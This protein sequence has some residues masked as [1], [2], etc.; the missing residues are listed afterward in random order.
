VAVSLT[1]YLE[2]RRKQR[3]HR[4]KDDYRRAKQRVRELEESVDAGIKKI[5]RLTAAYDQLAAE[6]NQLA[7]QFDQA[8]IDLTVAREELR[9]AEETIRLRDREI[10]DLERRVDIGVKAEHA[11]TQTQEIPIV[12][13]PQHRVVPLHESP[14]ADPAH[15]PAWA[16][17][18][19]TRPIPAA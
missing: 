16:R 11:V 18:D 7:D 5:G 12:Q 13:A 10:A 15:I 3:K 9:Q 1:D 4:L 17:D 8:Q 19:D 14:L 2:G 6:R